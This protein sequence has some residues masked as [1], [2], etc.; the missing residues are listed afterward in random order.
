MIY[1]LLLSLLT[2]LLIY[3]F[4]FIKSYSFIKTKVEL[5]SLLS[6]DEIKKLVIHNIFQFKHELNKDAVFYNDNLSTELNEFFNT[7]KFIKIGDYQFGHEFIKKFEDSVQYM[8][9]G[10][11]TY[12]SKDEYN[13]ALIIKNK[14]N[15]IMHVDDDNGL[16]IYVWMLNELLYTK[17][18]YI[19]NINELKAVINKELND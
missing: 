2:I 17:Y 7:Y 15:E 16:S 12:Y 3:G 14:S 4:I 9:V 18:S 8:Q 5:V 6:N 1:I 11:D 13:S 10:V 19:K